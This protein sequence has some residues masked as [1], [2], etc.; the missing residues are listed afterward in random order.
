MLFGHPIQSVN[1]Y[2]GRMLEVVKTP[3]ATLG[4]ERNH[5]FETLIA[6]EYSHDTD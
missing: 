5:F 1:T 2:I 6:K 3:A 4:P